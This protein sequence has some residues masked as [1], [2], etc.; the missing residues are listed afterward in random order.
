MITPDFTKEAHRLVTNAVSTCDRERDISRSLLAAYS[1]GLERAAEIADE[2]QMQL[3]GQ[4]N[5]AGC[6][7][8]AIRAEKEK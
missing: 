2:W 3:E 4:S 7:A 5:H 1:A 8:A 6:V